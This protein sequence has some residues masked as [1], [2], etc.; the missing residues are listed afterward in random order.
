MKRFSHFIFMALG[1]MLSLNA[2]AQTD[3]TASYLTNPSFEADAAKCNSS[4]ELK[5][6][7]EG[8]R[9]W[10]LSSITGWTTTSPG[11]QLLISAD[12]ATD[13][14]FGKTTIADGTYAFYQRFGW[15]SATGTLSQKT[16]AALPAGKY[17]MTFRYKAFAANGAVSSCTPEV[18]ATTTLGSETYS[19]EAGSTDIMGATSWSTGKVVFTVAAFGAV[20]RSF[21]G[22]TSLPAQFIL[23][24]AS[25][26]RTVFIMPL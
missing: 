16:T 8:L 17:Q 9:G 2:S 5:E 15:G 20:K 19:F 11:K 1:T 3:V 4:T 10:N 13:N 22:S 25:I 24:F 21:V 7:T 14:S 6:G 18:R 23:P 12:C 26:P